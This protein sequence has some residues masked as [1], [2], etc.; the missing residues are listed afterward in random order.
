MFFNLGS[1]LYLLTMEKEVEDFTGRKGD[2]S[3]F[4]DLHTHKHI[5][6][7]AFFKT[8]SHCDCVDLGVVFLLPL[9]PGYS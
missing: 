8:R 1:H 5:H 9:P 6:P 2:K 7:T 4:A 3:L